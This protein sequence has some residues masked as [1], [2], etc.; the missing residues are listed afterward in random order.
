MSAGRAFKPAQLGAL[1]GAASLG[2]LVVLVVAAVAL[3]SGGG[4]TGTDT[5]SQHV[6]AAEGGV[7]AMPGGPSVTFPPGALDRDTEVRIQLNDAPPVS[8]SGIFSAIGPVYTISMGD[9]TLASP[10]ELAFDE[11]E[12]DKEAIIA[13]Y[14]PELGAWIPQA[15]VLSEGKARTLTDH[16]SEYTYDVSVDMVAL[17]HIL[18]GDLQALLNRLS[19]TA[20]SPSS[21]GTSVDSSRGNG[22][23]QGCIAGSGT[24]GTSQLTTVRIHNMSLFP[25]QYCDLGQKCSDLIWPNK[26]IERSFSTS[27]TID[28]TLEFNT[29]SRTI[30]TIVFFRISTSI[31]GAV[32]GVPYFEVPWKTFEVI[33]EE[34]ESRPIVGGVLR[35]F[36]EAWERAPDLKSAEAA[37]E[38]L[39]SALDDNA[40]MSELA[41]ALEATK[42]RVRALAEDESLQLFLKLMAEHALGVPGIALKALD[43]AGIAVELADFAGKRRLGDSSFV[44]VVHDPTRVAPV[45]SSLG[46]PT[47][48]KLGQAFSCSP[49]VTGTVATWK[50]STPPNAP[51]SPREATSRQF[52]TRYDLPGNWR[53]TL[54]ACNGETSC[55][56]ESQV[57]EVTPG[58]PPAP[59]APVINSLGCTPASVATGGS[60]TCNPSITGNVSSRSWSASGGSPSSGSGSSFSTSYGSA[61]SKTISLQACNGSACS[62]SSQTVTVQAPQANAP[63][64]NSLGCSPTSVNISQSVS[65]SPSISGTVTSRSWSASG[66]SPSS[67]SGTS[68]STSYGTAGSKTISLQACNGSACSN[69]SQTITVS[70]PAAQVPTA[71][72]N[73]GLSEVYYVWCP[74][75]D[76][77]HWVLGWDDNSDNESG[78]RIYANGTLV[79]SAAANETGAGV[80][81]VIEGREGTLCFTVSA[82]NA[83]GESAR[84]GGSG[85]ACRS[86]SVS[87]HL[88]LDLNDLPD[89]HSFTI[90]QGISLCYWLTPSNVPYG[91]RLFKSTNGS[92]YELIDQWSDTGGGDCIDS[93]VGSP[94][95]TRTYLA[96]AVVNGA[97]VA[98]DTT[99]IQ[100][101]GAQS[102]SF[103]GTLA[104][105]VGHVGPGD[106][107]LMQWTSPNSPMQLC[108]HLTPENVP[109]TV[110]ISI[111]R[112][113]YYLNQWQGVGSIEDNGVGG[114]GCLDIA[115]KLVSAWPSGACYG[116]LK[117]EA[118]IQGT[119]VGE[120][121]FSINRQF[122]C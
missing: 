85:A 16:F 103:S 4:G 87:Y 2:V 105:T 41:E 100:V 36:F 12:S 81:D 67:G 49:A 80:D 37:V 77:P 55:D 29:N 71:P 121:N 33:V 117:V 48:I 54:T 19:P 74:D 47:A 113:T 95:G 109:F 62:N 8:R 94:A 70:N 59:S 98:E 102:Y 119:T 97:V 42:S 40:F 107:A 63:T 13:F 96:Q 99:W 58:D 10:A 66:G 53:I 116:T 9:A 110:R 90:G 114:G 15:T 83:A 104:G 23:V 52:D 35:A 44:R 5:V 84:V 17:R 56:E 7:V 69:S 34:L 88:T 122:G 30:D 24:L 79:G 115:S 3:T 14:D 86:F 25:I 93:T 60:I 39:V 45:I 43:L 38:I 51:S 64:I 20:C 65:C 28:T 68:F 31:I 72:S 61:G 111:T 1:A 82:F 11:R 22:V 27:D 46:C 92:Q 73:I 76:C 21:N 50:W 32:S 26:H 78:F 118:V 91:V 18:R 108:Y 75:G 112:G 106:T 57:V 89:G 120:I 101:T 6:T